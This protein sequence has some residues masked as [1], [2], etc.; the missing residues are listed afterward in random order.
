MQPFFTE[1]AAQQYIDLNHH[2]HKELRI[3]V[4]SGLHLIKFNN[5]RPLVIKNW[6]GKDGFVLNGAWNLIVDT[7]KR[8]YTIQ[9]VEESFEYETLIET[10]VPWQLRNKNYNDIILEMEGSDK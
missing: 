1:K 4:Q 9:E 3:Y 6:N 7:D 5:D 10:P 8:T 2:R